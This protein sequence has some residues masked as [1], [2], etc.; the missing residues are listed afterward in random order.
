M[1]SSLPSRSI[2]P[3]L[4]AGLA[5][6]L[7][8]GP[9][10]AAF[11]SA[12]ASVVIQGV[13]IDSDSAGSSFEAVSAGKVLSSAVNNATAKAS[14]SSGPGQLRALG[15]GG[16]GLRKATGLGEAFATYDDVVVSW[17]ATNDPHDLT[18]TI[19]LN[20]SLDVSQTATGSIG[21]KDF[22]NV[23][24]VHFAVGMMSASHNGSVLFRPT[25]NSGLQHLGSN[26]LFAEVPV[27][28]PITIT[29][30]LLAGA[31]ASMQGTE[32]VH[33]STTATLTV[34]SRTDTQP[35]FAHGSSTAF[36][37]QFGRG[38]VFDLPAGY[39]V[40]SVSM[41]IVDNQWI[42]APVPEPA[43]WLMMGLGLSL[44]LGRR[45]FGARASSLS[46]G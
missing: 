4:V 32:P 44:L 25:G 14:A 21:N 15:V 13:A 20:Y 11:Y 46:R 19:G 24:E 36:A 30:S 5:L 35:S 3:V 16:S 45:R 37:P 43:S 9:A 26:V 6:L 12:K 27:G 22:L 7:G 8:P 23:R 17:A 41:G 31:S 42:F 33:V 2:R 40:N 29:F 18:A 34:S 38:P 28:T 10:S 39:T 1:A